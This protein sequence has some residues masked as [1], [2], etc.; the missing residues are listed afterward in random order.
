MG[1]VS[2]NSLALAVSVASCWLSSSMHWKH[3]F[4]GRTDTRRDVER[5]QNGARSILESRFAYVSNK[6][7]FY[8]TMTKKSNIKLLVVQS[9]LYRQKRKKPLSYI[10]KSGRNHLTF[11][12]TRPIKTATAA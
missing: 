11:A 12:S 4:P 3:P 10:D 1:L 7:Q 8:N 2:N 6:H 5:L 9:V